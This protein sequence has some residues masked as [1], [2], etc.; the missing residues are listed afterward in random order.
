MDIKDHSRWIG[1][2]ISLLRV[3]VLLRRLQRQ[4]SSTK[5]ILYHSVKGGIPKY[6]PGDTGEKTRNCPRKCSRIDILQAGDQK[7]FI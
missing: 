7:A 5:D 1:P 4:E 3:K 2:R 6:N